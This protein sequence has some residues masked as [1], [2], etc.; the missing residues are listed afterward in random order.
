M[1]AKLSPMKNKKSLS[2]SP[3]EQEKQQSRKAAKKEAKLLKKSRQSA[4]DHKFRESEI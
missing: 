1:K 3:E 2:V 4:K